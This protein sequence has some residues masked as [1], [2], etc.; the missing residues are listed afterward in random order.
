M[1]RASSS[2]FVPWVN[3][4]TP[5][6]ARLAER[7][8]VISSRL[9]SKFVLTYLSMETKPVMPKATLPVSVSA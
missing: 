1:P 7:L 9:S 6:E 2:F 5:F 8:S 4:P 3:M